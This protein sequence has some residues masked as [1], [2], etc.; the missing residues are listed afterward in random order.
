MS[1]VHVHVSEY[2]RLV[3]VFKTQEEQAT[4]SKGSRQKPKEKADQARD[5]Q[6]DKRRMAINKKALSGG[7]TGAVA[8]LSDMD[9]NSFS[10]QFSQEKFI[11]WASEAPREGNAEASSR[12]CGHHSTREQGCPASRPLWIALL[13]PSRPGL[14]PGTSPLGSWPEGSLLSLKALWSLQAESLPVDRASQW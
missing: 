12:G 2:L 6:K 13:D 4:S 5:T 9:Q 10:G 8:P 7:M 3:F 14:L 11:R 1:P